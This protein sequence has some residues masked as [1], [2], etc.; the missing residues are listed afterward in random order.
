MFLSFR[1]GGE[2]RYLGKGVLKAVESVNTTLNSALKGG[3]PPNSEKLFGGGARQLCP[4]K[5]I[6]SE[7][8]MSFQRLN[9]LKLVRVKPQLIDVQGFLVEVHGQM[10]MFGHRFLCCQGNPL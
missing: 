2:A 1:L 9:H 3:D 10:R 8:A 5:G 7:M 4:V 6:P